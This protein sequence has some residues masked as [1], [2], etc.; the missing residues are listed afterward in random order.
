MT[1]EQLHETECPGCGCEPEAEAY[2]KR[3]AEYVGYRCS[4]RAI[5]IDGIVQGQG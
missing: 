1:K 4:C 2:F 5:V 3:G